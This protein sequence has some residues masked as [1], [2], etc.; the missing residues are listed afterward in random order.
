MSMETAFELC[1]GLVDE[2]IEIPLLGV[3]AA[4][5]PYKAF[6]VDDT[7]SVPAALWGGRKVFALRVRGT[8]MIDEGIHDGDFLI[9]QPCETAENGQTVVAEID[10]CVTVKKFFRESDGAIRLQPANPALLPLIVRGDNICIRG[11]VV[12]VMRKYGFGQHESARSVRHQS[13]ARRPLEPP[14]QQTED[15]FEFSLNAIDAQLARWQM[16]LEQAKHD[17]RRRTQLP[18]MAELGR[19]LQALRDWLGRTAKPGLRRALI[20]EANN[21]I[22]RMQRFAPAP[23]P[24]P[25]ETLL[26]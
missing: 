25:S 18:Q 19:D 26:H 11:V 7:L 1:D 20:T 6:V 3:V 2:T 15:M 24:G 12:G 14:S 9:V 21:L 13:P 4:G 10:G 8:S 23:P 17:R 22:R 5:E 16:V